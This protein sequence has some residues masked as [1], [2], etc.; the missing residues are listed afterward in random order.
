MVY[1]FLLFSFY[2]Y[3]LGVL[4]HLLSYNFVLHPFDL[5]LEH[6]VKFQ[7]LAGQFLLLLLH[8]ENLFLELLINFLFLVLQ[9]L[10]QFPLDLLF[11]DLDLAVNDLLLPPLLLLLLSLQFVF[12][13]TFIIF[14]LLVH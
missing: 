3:L 9:L 13:I 5:V 6:V 11:L 12:G 4:L 14:K 1:L 8:D 2:L 7:G 10:L